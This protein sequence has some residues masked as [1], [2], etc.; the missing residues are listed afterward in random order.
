MKFYSTNNP[1]KSFSFQESFELGIAPDG[2]LFMPGFLPVYSEIDESFSLNQIAFNISKLFIEEIDE[3]NLLKLTKN[4]FDFDSPLI[5][6]DENIFVLELFHGPT[7]AFKDFGALFLSKFQSY[8]SK[9]NNKDIAILVA[10]SGDTGSAVANAFLNVDGVKVVLLYPSGKV[11][12]IQEQQLTTLGGNIIAIEVDGTFDDCQSLVKSAFNDIQLKNKLR[13][14]SANSINIGRL[15]PQIFYYFRAYSQL[16]EKGLPLYFS[17]PSGNLGNLTAGLFAK[18]IGLPVTKFI[19]SL[20]VNKT[21]NS[22]L[23]TGIFTP[24]DAVATL[25]NAMDVG[26]PSNIA[27]IKNLYQ[28][29]FKSITKDISAH[30]FSDDE[31]TKCI[32]DVY[33]MYNYQIC[34]HTAIGF[35]GIRKFESLNQRVKANK[36]ILSTA[37]PGKFQTTVQDSLGVKVKLPERLEQSLRKVKTSIKLDSQFQNFKSLL[38]ELL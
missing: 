16:D 13:L 11:S 33:Q 20:N 35:L 28:N 5:Q 37:H 34:P 4:L 14:T 9:K 8:Y 31:T 19:S 25:S 23:E 21:F 26:N 17:V 30:S 22:Y 10:T 38:N 32:K 24:K 29:N 2:G 7:L 27:R 36:I 18:K 1:K 15:I 6:L 12:K 3:S